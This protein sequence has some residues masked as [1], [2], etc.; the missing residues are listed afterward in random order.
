MKIKKY[1]LSEFLNLNTI[2]N[3]RYSKV[4]KNYPY[5][6]TNSKHSSKITKE[7]AKTK[8]IVLFRMY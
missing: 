5:F 1:T 7:L 2:T 8:H 4:K 6:L 3:A